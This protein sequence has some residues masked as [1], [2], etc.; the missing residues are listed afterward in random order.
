[1][2]KIFILLLSLSLTAVSCNQLLFGGTGAMGVFKSEDSGQSSSAA[3]KIDKKNN[4]NSTSVNS[5]VFGF[6]DSQTIYLASSAGVYKSSDAG[7]TWKLM[8]TNIA[9]AD[10]AADATSGTLYVAGLSDNHGKIVKTADDGS[11]WSDVYTEPTSGNTVRS[12]AVDP[13]NH[14]QVFAGL[15]AGEIIVSQDFG[16]TWQVVTDLH[17]VIY[18]LRFGP[19]GNLYVLTVSHGLYESRDGGK[20][21]TDLSSTLTN[22]FI[23][24]DANFSSV[25]K[26]LDLAFDQKQPGVLYLATDAGLIRS[27]DDGM[28]WA[29]MQMPVRNA[30][31]RTSAVAVDPANS[32][33]LYAVVGNTLFKSTNGGAAWETKPLASGQ[34]VRQILIDYSSPNVIYLGMGAAK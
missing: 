32:N 31:L 33:N 10:V 21:F 8:L 6:N 18:R 22:G 9:V 24:P 15:S 7:S 2:K 16:L 28:N 30:E 34:E 17:D 3:N 13:S 4:L 29:F 23:N 19:N 11:S 14:A 5:L 20:T 27:V 26:F 12:L 1:M 25:S